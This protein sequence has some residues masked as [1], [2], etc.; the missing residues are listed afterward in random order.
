MPDVAQHHCTR[1]WWMRP[2]V[3]FI[4]IAAALLVIFAIFEMSGRPA[5]TSY[6]TFLDQL[7]VGN[8][9]SVTFQ[10]TQIDGRF[11]QPLNV[12]ASKDTVAADTFRSHVPDFGDA[13]LIPELRKQHVAIDVASSTSWTRLLAGVPFPMWL[14]LGAILVAGIVRLVRGGKSQSGSAMPTHPM[15]GMIGLVTGLFGKQTQPAAGPPT[16]DGNGT[17]SG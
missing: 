2:P 5:T 7:N 12:T 10:G 4:G 14:F 11:K 6:G 13:S 8:V 3:W 17:K 16:Q 15:Q 9:A 1:S